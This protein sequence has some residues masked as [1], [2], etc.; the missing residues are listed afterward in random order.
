MARPSARASRSPG[1]VFRTP[2]A[3]RGTVG[4][5]Q[6]LPRILGKRLAKDL[7]FTGRDLGVEEARTAGFVARIA[8]DL[9]AVKKDISEKIEKAN[10]LAMRLA[11]RSIDRG[12]EL[13]PAGAKAVELEAIEE[14]LASGSFLGSR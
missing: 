12:I 6:R 4:A 10:P 2:E 11:K 14:Q 7:M 9:D 13:D 1:T 5:T 3:V 8:S